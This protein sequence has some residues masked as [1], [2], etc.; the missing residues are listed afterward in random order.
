[1]TVKELAES[2]DYKI[3]TGGKGLENEVT[4]CYCGDLLSWVMGRAPADC[5]WITVMSNTNVVAVA[6]LAD[7]A[8]VIIAE[9]AELDADALDRALRAG[10]LTGAILD[11]FDHEPLEDDSPLWTTPNLIMTPHVSSDDPVNYIPRSLD[12]LMRNV[13]NY[14]EGKPLENLVDTAREF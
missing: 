3:I 14:L 5:V 13:R 2:L 12:I 7:V 4:G 1:M 8:C 6:S 10:K 11:V 9:G